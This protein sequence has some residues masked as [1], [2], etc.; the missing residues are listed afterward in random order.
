MIVCL[1]VGYLREG[2]SGLSRVAAQRDNIHYGAMFPNVQ[3]PLTSGGILSL[4]SIQ[5][6]WTLV[7]LADPNCEPCRSELKSLQKVSQV[8]GDRLRIVPVIEGGLPFR[9]GATEARDYSK[10]QGLAFDIAIDKRRMLGAF[11]IDDMHVLPKSTLFDPQGICRFETCG[12][13]RTASYS[14]ELADAMLAYFHG[15]SI[16]SMPMTNWK[17]IKPIKD[18][19]VRLNTGKL[20]TISHLSMHETLVVTFLMGTSQAELR[21]ISVLRK[22]YRAQGVRF[23]Y[24]V[25]NPLLVP[26]GM[27]KTGSVLISSHD[28]APV[29]AAYHVTSGPVT[30]IIYKGRVIVREVNALQSGEALEDALAYAILLSNSTARTDPKNRRS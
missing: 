2:K 15:D 1:F 24:V 3:V 5:G 20:D 28:T 19:A 10:R 22:Y 14:S 29:F 16:G 12:F 30:V 7:V 27:D 17:Q 25:D 26:T 8:L 23:L 11:M 6:K 21:R 4:N 9:D 13:S 18:V